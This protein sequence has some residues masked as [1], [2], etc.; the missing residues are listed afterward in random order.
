MTI[1]KAKIKEFAKEFLNI[2]NKANINSNKD[3][4]DKIY[5]NDLKHRLNKNREDFVQISECQS[6]GTVAQVLG[7]KNHGVTPIE[8]EINHQ[9]SYN[10]L[11]IRCSTIL[12]GY[13]IDETC[14]SGDYLQVK[15]TKPADFPRAKDEVR[16][17]AE[18][19]I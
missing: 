12:D 10:K 15:E 18:L 14:S 4:F 19:V 6:D 3:V 8:I 1:T 9:K 13:G 7:Y 2:L 5:N 16:G 11:K 17:L